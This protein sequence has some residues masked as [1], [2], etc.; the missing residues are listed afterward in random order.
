MTQFA[1]DVRAGLG[2]PG[3]KWIPCKYFYDV[4]GSAL[5]EAITLLPEYGLT[6]ADERIISRYAGEIAD[7][8]AP[9][10]VVVEL[11]SG[12]AKKTRSI[13]EALA[14]R[15]PTTYHPIEISPAA[16]VLT[17]RELGHLDGVSVRGFEA[18]YLDG[19]A[20][21]AKRLP[22]QRLMV[23]FLGSS[24]GN[25]N[26]HQD[27]EFLVRI[28]AFLQVGDA[29]LLGTD[30]VK[31]TSQT[32]L[33][34]DDPAGVTAAFNLNLLARI[35]RELGADF[36]L[37]RFAHQVVYNEGDR[38]IEMH[39]RSTAEQRVRIEKAR[40]DVHFRAG[41]T[42][43]TES[44]HKYTLGDVGQMATATGFRA[45]R[46]WVDEEWPF[47]ESLLVAS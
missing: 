45:A 4:V 26:R 11:G 14:R 10:V 35:N 41:E 29:V 44:S 6:R 30:L 13:L 21:A 34:Y 39:L 23:L 17:H 18:E 20:R 33:A 12:S 25:F 43:W 2:R 40:L 47:A 3:S 31:P 24:I 38:R 16:L 32:I 8:V 1:R 15:Q 28:R 37:R 42:I 5:F 7:S 9:P 19:L 36:N 22:R 27:S 46:Q